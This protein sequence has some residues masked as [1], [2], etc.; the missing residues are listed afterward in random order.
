MLRTTKAAVVA[1]LTAS[2]LAL[3]GGTAVAESDGEATAIGSPGVLSG[4][5]ISVPI[6][7]PVNAC[8]N[9]LNLI[10]LLNPTSGNTCVNSETE[11]DKGGPRGH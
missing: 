3:G 5:A 9:S 1:V 7:I 11:V 4:N 8:G 6:H 10:G 2:A